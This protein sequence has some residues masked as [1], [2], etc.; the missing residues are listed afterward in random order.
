MRSSS[1][2]ANCTY[3]RPATLVENGGM[4]YPSVMAEDG[5]LHEIQTRR[6]SGE[7]SLLDLGSQIGY[8]RPVA[9]VRKEGAQGGYASIPLTRTMCPSSG[10][11]FSVRST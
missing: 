5:N 1:R 8:C 11:P 2:K 9:S 6:G 4:E 10:V 7:I 3:G